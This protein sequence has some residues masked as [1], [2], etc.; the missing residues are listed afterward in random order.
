MPKNGLFKQFGDAGGDRRPG[1][2]GLSPPDGDDIAATAGPRV[3]TGGGRRQPWWPG[4]LGYRDF[5][6]LWLGQLF[7]LS[8]FWM[9]NVAQ[10][11]LVLELSDSPLLLGTVSAAAN[12]P[13]FLLSL[14]GGAVA[15]RVDRAR[16]VVVT[17]SVLAALT[18][19]LALL[20]TLELITIP[21]FVGLVAAMG[22]VWAFDI[23]ARQSL[24][25]ALVPRR[26]IQDAIALNS[27]VVNGTRIVAPALAGV[28]VGLIGVA[29]VYWLTAACYLGLVWMASK[30]R[31]RDS[32]AGDPPVRTTVWQDVVE[33]L[34]YIWSNRLV[35]S[36]L[37]VSLIPAVFGLAY[38]PLVPVFA[39]DILRV[40]VGGLG[41]L[42]GASGA[43]ALLGSGAVALIGARFPR[44]PILLWSGLAF[45]LTVVGFALVPHFGFA[46]LA[47]TAAG[48]TQALFQTLNTSLA[49]GA[50]PAAYQG[51]VMSIYMLTW[52]LQSL[53]SLF[54]GALAD[55]AGAPLA[56]AT[57]GVI[58]LIFI[59][60]MWA[61]AR[62]LRQL[63]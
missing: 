56:V 45:S 52:G 57:T 27:V 24:I 19:V 3:K 6:L 10:G 55:R 25:P 5:R 38:V 42:Y 50:I 49:L 44:G 51:R 21:I 7:A 28:L 61:A 20:I 53:G 17:R 16:L 34:G 9:Q 39:R 8:G 58:S 40:G 41:L 30:I 2:A 43:G 62:P 1:G 63:R 23:P 32:A 46:L 26:A 33:G 37:L 36:L 31:P 15:D 48:F 12:I 29:G 35:F 47:L 60:G 54:A 14:L 13:I 59:L 22:V 4:V 18:A 11:W